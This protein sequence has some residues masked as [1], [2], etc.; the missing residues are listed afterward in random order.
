MMDNYTALQSTWDESLGSRLGTEVKSRVIGVKAQ[1]ET[2]NFF[3][4]V[5]LGE[6]I[7]RHADNLSKTLQS[8]SISAAG[9]QKVA[10]LTLKTLEGIRTAQQFDLFWKL[11]LLKSSKLDISER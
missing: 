11:V 4:G 1:M 3:F 5:C 6:Y 9:G 10:A 2:L 8:S 7:L